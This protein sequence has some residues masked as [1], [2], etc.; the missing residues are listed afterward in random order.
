MRERPREREP[1]SR[2]GILMIF[3][4]IPH[5]TVVLD[6]CAKKSTKKSVKKWK[7]KSSRPS[8]FSSHQI[9]SFERA[10]KAAHRG[11]MVSD[12]DISEKYQS[13]R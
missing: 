5:L 11:R 2:L 12:C 10:T 8:R 13:P 7:E 3:L 1:K 9:C 4:F 6:V